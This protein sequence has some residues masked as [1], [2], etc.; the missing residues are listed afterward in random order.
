MPYSLKRWK[1]F[2]I[3]GALFP[4]TYAYSEYFTDVY[5]NLLQRRD[6]WPRDIKMHRRHIN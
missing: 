3:L 2:N 1:T 4:K 6:Y 5:V